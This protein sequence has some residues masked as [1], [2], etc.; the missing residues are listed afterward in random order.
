MGGSLNPVSDNPE[1]VN[2]PRH[3]FN[4]WFDP[5]AAYVV[6]RAP[7]K[8]IVCTPVDISIKARFTKEMVKRIGTAGTPLAK[9]IAQ[10]YQPGDGNDYM[11][12]E[13]AAAAWIDPSIITKKETR[14][15]SVNIDHGAS[16]GDTLTWFENDKPELTVQPVE[17]H[18]DLDASKF[19]D[20]FESMMTSPI[21]TH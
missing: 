4:F 15:M 10:Y 18:V 5:E 11:W 6:L 13:L 12:D 17:I 2:S 7:W 8:K 14:F 21:Q 3:E 1:F 16:Y 9:Y 20:M 19:F